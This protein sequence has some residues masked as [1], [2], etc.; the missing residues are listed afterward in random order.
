MYWYAAKHDATIKAWE[1]GKRKDLEIGRKNINKFKR[2]LDT[3][4]YWCYAGPKQ[5]TVKEK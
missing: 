1:Q 5:P 4:T 3:S 2:G